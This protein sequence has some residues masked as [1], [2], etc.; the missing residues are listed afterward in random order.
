LPFNSQP[1][2]K[3]A[4]L[5]TFSTFKQNDYDFAFIVHLLPS[6][7]KRLVSSIILKYQS[8]TNILSVKMPISS[9]RV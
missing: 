9:K 2:K 4:F 1:H 8:D 5:V 3:I 7:Y 6:V